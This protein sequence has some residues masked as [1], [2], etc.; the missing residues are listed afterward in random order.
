MRS[1]KELRN[2]LLLYHDLG[3]IDD[4]ELLLLCSSYESKNPDFP[5]D[6]FPDFNL[7][8]MNEAECV[9]E[10]RFR[11]EDI[12]ILAE[13]LQIPDYFVCEQN[14]ICNGLTGLCILLKRLAYP[15]RYSDMVAR[16][17]R[18]VPVLS[19]ITNTVLDYIYNQHGFRLTRWNDVLMNPEMLQI[20]ANTISAKGAPLDMCFG[21]IDGTLVRIC[22]PGKNQRMMYNGHKRVHAIKFQSVAL[23]NG[24]IGNLYGP[25]GI[26]FHGRH[27]LSKVLNLIAKI[28]VLCFFTSQKEENMTLEC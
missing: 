5:Y 23:P 8:V 4:E 16:F 10:F 14:S 18:P 3:I 9:A 15:C 11:K 7:E 19:M 28:L 1:F 22:R 17:G 12:P 2:V 27:H 20:Y 24:M 21:F 6:S 25:T 13:S 26:Y